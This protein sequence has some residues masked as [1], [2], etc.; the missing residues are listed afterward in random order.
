VSRLFWI[1][2]GAAA[3]FAVSRKLAQTA[4]AA[5]PAGIAGNLGDALSELATAIGGFGADVRAGMTERE[6]ELTAEVERKTGFNPG[7]RHALRAAGE[8]WRDSVP[9]PA[10]RRRAPGARANRADG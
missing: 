2:V 5:T 10:P 3:G 1:G 8:Q 4:R 9:A 7:P 6:D